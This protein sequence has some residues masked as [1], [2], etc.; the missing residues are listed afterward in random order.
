MPILPHRV[1]LKSKFLKNSWPWKDVL[2][3]VV[4]AAGGQGIALI[5][6]PIVTRIYEPSALGLQGIFLSILSFITPLMSLRLPLAIVIAK[7]VHQRRLL[8]E[9]SIAVAFVN[10]VALLFLL[11]IVWFLGISTKVIHELGD[12]INLLPLAAFCVAM[13]EVAE[14]NAIRMSAFNVAARANIIASGFT[15][16]GKLIGGLISSSAITLVVI[17]ALSPLFHVMCI[18]SGVNG[19]VI[20]TGIRPRQFHFGSRRKLVFAQQVICRFREFAFIR[21]PTDAIS[22]A[23]QFAPAT[24]L[25]YLFGIEATGYFVLARSVM[26]FPLNI[27]GTA[28][29][30]VYYSKIA[31]LKHSNQ[32]ILPF[33][34]LSTFLQLAV[35]GCIILAISP[36]MPLLFPP[37]FGEKWVTAGEFAAWLGLCVFGMIGNIPTV[38]TLPVIE[39]QSLHFIFSIINFSLGIAGMVL[40]Y[41]LTGSAVGSVAFYSAATLLTYIGQ[42]IWYFRVIRRFDSNQS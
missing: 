25:S 19:R 21:A 1:V 16:F 27:I 17:T 5:C 7:T 28:V 15:N 38:R 22:A 32:P 11:Q 2:A 37:L 30:N 24:V 9:I 20:G 4:G 34:V 23:A 3:A 29:G 10:A 41:Q 13:Q 14:M 33:V 12:L 18:L 39:A 35:P 26:S 31:D 36:L 8:I 40:G 6:M 42:T